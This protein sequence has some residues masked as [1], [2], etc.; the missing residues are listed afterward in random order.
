VRLKQ[1]TTYFELRL[2]QVYFKSV[3]HIHFKMP[4]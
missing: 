4:R 2:Q 1:K 3:K